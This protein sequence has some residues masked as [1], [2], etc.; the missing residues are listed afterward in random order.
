MQILSSKPT[1]F[2]VEI[3]NANFLIS[4]P[5][6]IT[7]TRPSLP[8]LHRRWAANLGSKAKAVD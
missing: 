3:A 4:A 7:V 6:G 1:A 2:Q 8:K 5:T